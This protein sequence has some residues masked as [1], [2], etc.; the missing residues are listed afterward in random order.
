MLYFYH[1]ITILKDWERK[2][3]LRR[4]QTMKKTLAMLLV[5]SMLI[6][7]VACAESADQPDDAADTAQIETEAQTEELSDA[8]KRKLIPDNLP[9]ANYEGYTFTIVGRDRGDF[10]ADIGA[11]LAETGDIVDDAIYKRNHNVE[12]RFNIT[13]DA[14][15]LSDPISELRKT[16]SS[17]DDSYQMMLAQ[18]IE[19]GIAA[20]EGN[21]LDWYEDLPYVNL[22]QPWYIGNAVEALSVENHAF[23]MAGEYDLSILRF[24]YCMFFNKKIA[25]DYNVENL[26]ALVNDGT[27]TIDKLDE[28]VAGVHEDLDGDGKIN[29]KD[30]VGFT[31][32]YYSAAITYQYAFDNPV[33]TKTEQGIPEVTFLNGKMDDIV[34]KL[35]DFFY[36]NEGSYPGGWGVSG[37]IWDAGHALFLNG[38]FQGCISYRDLEFDFGIIPYPKWDEAQATYYTMSDGA[39]DLQSVPVTVQDTERASVIIE[40]LNA[41]SYKEVIPVYYDIALKVKYSRDEESVQVL[42]Q[43][44]AARTFDFGYIYD[45]WKGYA[46]VLQECTSSKSNAFASK[47]AAKQKSAERQYQKVIDTLLG[48]EDD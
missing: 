24:T 17:Q 45:G 37:P 47:A 19:V 15:H 29:D 48:L 20:L 5:L 28:I 35:T 23:I 21:Y 41:E 9:E 12:D 38:L 10:V 8:E 25:E 43:L 31:T 3:Y 27:W 22:E 46:F 26:Y 34:N 18:A 1:N 39:H 2:F 14:N 36:N 30:L 32:D 6:T 11:G 4:K 13:I 42:D 44:L 16:V 7:A 40:A 33:M